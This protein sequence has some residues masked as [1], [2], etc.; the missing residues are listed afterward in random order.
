[1]WPSALAALLALHEGR[2]GLSAARRA[3]VGVLGTVDNWGGEHNYNMA[4]AR[5]LRVLVATATP[6]EKSNR[7]AVNAD[8]MLTSDE[9]PCTNAPTLQPPGFAVDAS[10]VQ[11][12]LTEGFVAFRP[13]AGDAA[14]ILTALRELTPPIVSSAEAGEALGEDP[15]VDGYGP[16]YLVQSEP[17]GQ[18]KTLDGQPTT[19]YSND[20][21][22]V[23]ALEA[24][25][26]SSDVRRTLTALLGKN[27][28][29]DADRS[30]N[31]TSPGR[32]DT[33]GSGG[34]SFHR[35]GYGKR[36]HQHPRML[37][38][39]YYP[40]KVTL[41]MGPT[42]IIARSQFI[43]DF[44]A[45]YQSPDVIR[46]ILPERKPYEGDYGGVIRGAGEGEYFSPPASFGVQRKI[47]VPAGT[48][49]IM[50]YD[51]W[52]RATPSLLPSDVE[53]PPEERD[54]DTHRYMTKFRFW[55][56]RGCCSLTRRV[57][58]ALVG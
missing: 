9:Q 35:D 2:R 39:L 7:R 58:S 18:A 1:M 11:R 4:A 27:Y 12:F 14:S 55:V 20:R 43:A 16:G 26:S 34:M 47:V 51:T 6:G 54:R 22:R 40:Q 49:V 50:F 17:G 21:P 57:D 32:V 45:G 5:R 52:H 48:L 41:E 25:L 53:V 24:M 44:N 31:F 19:D 46:G 33:G 56:R 38:G 3:C 30:A 13:E 8:P 29:V 15:H 42:A 23:P 28:L 10:M 36:R 37:M